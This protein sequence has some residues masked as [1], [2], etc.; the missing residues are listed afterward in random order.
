LWFFALAIAAGVLGFLIKKLF[1]YIKQRE[2]WRLGFNAERAVGEQLNQLMSEGCRVFHDFPLA[3]NWNIDHIIV[4]P[5]GVFAVETRAKRKGAASETLQAH[6]VVYDGNSLQ[7]PFQTETYDLL[8]TREQAL[9]LEN[10][11]NPQLKES[12]VSVQPV[13][14]LPGW[15]VISR[16]LGEVI[17]LNPR[18][19][20][21]AILSPG[22][23]NLSPERIKEI[24]RLIDQKCRDVE[25]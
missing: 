15:S 2:N 9:R 22:P 21:S 14:T 25:F 20:E 24:A 11:L 18:F 19:M 4:A 3:E 23:I 10:F 13:L 12:I 16:A 5:T 17:V 1:D 6:E 8:R 7:Y